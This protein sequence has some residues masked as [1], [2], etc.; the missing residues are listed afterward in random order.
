MVG[1][2]RGMS[3][4]RKLESSVSSSAARSVLIAICPSPGAE[5]Y[6]VALGRSST[7]L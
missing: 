7:C 3:A 6:W 4:P 1:A 2:S 5:A